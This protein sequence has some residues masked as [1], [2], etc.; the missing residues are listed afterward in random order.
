MKPYYQDALV[1]IYH[2]N[3]REVLPL[4][5]GIQAVIT[6]PPYGVKFT[7]KA[8][9]DTKRNDGYAAAIG[10]D[11]QFI[12]TV[13]VPAVIMALSISERGA[14][15]TGI[16]SLFL[17]P[18]PV[19]MGGFF[20]ESGGGVGPWGFTSYHP[21]CYYGKDPF[22]Q[23]RMGSR[24]NSWLVCETAKPNGHP[25]PK[26]IGWMRRLVQRCSWENETVLDPFMGSG[27]HSAP[28]RN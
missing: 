17:Y 10:D 14:V 2:G 9:K 6:D 19:D 7:G 13:V 8:T 15:F 3:C 24:P 11:E 16:R 5:S 28:L 21:V 22:L 4:L 1:T 23:R 12:V 18:K 26:P 27:Q 20:V 25:C